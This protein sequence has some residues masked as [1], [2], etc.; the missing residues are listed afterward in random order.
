MTYVGSTLKLGKRFFFLPC[1][2]LMFSHYEISEGGHH[3]KSY[4]LFMFFPEDES[5]ILI[6]H[7][8]MPLLFVREFSGDVKYVADFQV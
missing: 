1:T 6:F 2:V 3:V 7:H 5:V 8:D 4:I